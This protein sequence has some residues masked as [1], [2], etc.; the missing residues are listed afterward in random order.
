MFDSITPGQAELVCGAMSTLVDRRSRGDLGRG[1]ALIDAASALLFHHPAG[2]G[3]RG[4]RGVPP[5]A[6]ARAVPAG[7]VL[8][9]ET[10]ELLAVTALADGRADPDRLLAAV[11][12]ADAL[13]VQAGWVEQLRDIAGGRFERALADMIRRN[14]ATFPGLGDAE[15]QPHMQP[16]TG[17][18][19]ADKRLADSFQEL[20]AYPA[21]TF[22]HA[23]WVH[24]RRHGFRFP[25]Q[26]GAFNGAFAVPHDGL[27]VLS[28]YDTSIQGELM[29]S[30]FTGEM[31]RTDALGAHILPVIFEWHVGMEVN[32]IGAQH[33]ALDPWKFVVALARGT[34]TRVDVLDPG[35]DFRHEARRPLA[36]LRHEYGI[37]PLEDRYRPSGPEVNVTAE[38]DPTAA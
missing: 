21:E 4:C 35:W 22:G 28:G 7:G 17:R 2:D 31:H 38:A 25:G 37:P 9:T 12:Y 3:G 33:D 19:D 24:F 1:E 16:Y 13:G 6:L 32:G 36:D 8:A 18:T 10:A 29:V 26:E 11:T 5:D 34:R 14:T 27:H 20:E 15:G 30:T 23:F